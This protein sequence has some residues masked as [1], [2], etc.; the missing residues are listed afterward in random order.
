MSAHLLSND[1]NSGFS[2]TRTSE[3]DIFM[4]FDSRILGPGAKVG[5]VHLFETNPLIH[6]IKRLTAGTC[7]EYNGLAATCLPA[8]RLY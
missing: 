3:D 5:E 8:L 7:S 1:S 4:Y 2:I 6:I